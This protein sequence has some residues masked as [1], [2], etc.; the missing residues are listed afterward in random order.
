MKQNKRNRKIVDIAV[1]KKQE[2]LIHPV[3]EKV[4]KALGFNLFEILFVR[5]NQENYLRLTIMHE[6]HPV[7]TNDCEIV[8]KS[9]SKELDSTDMIPFSYILEIQSK[10]IDEVISPS[11]KHEFIL[12]KVGLTVRS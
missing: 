1:L 6:D 12:E 5:E 9:V 11:L 10:G 2:A 4:V 8:S 7:S 3:L